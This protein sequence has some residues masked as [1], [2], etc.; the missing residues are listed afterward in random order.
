MTTDLK[1]RKIQ[2]K[3]K[4]WSSES[5]K[6]VPSCVKN[7]DRSRTFRRLAIAFNDECSEPKNQLPRN[8]RY[9]QINYQRKICILVL[10]YFC[11][12]DGLLSERHRK[13]ENLN[14]NK[15]FCWLQTGAIL[16]CVT[17]NLIWDDPSEWSS[18]QRQLDKQVSN[19][20]LKRES[21]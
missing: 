5:G 9:L 4:I 16:L 2:R 6:I 21:E 15:R 20:R 10:N 8:I 11:D 18:H 14:E 7:T 13:N 1:T 19:A 12:H 3:T 17:G